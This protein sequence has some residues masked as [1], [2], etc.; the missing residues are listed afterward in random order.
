MQ[1]E[2]H[3]IACAHIHVYTQLLLE[4]KR[5]LE[6]SVTFHWPEP[7]KKTLQADGK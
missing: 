3:T 7:L 6:A 5:S 2:I 4:K 1:K